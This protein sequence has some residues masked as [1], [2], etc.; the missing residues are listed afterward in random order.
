MSVPA[1]GKMALYRNPLPEV[2]R[3]F[4]TRHPRR[5]L[6]F[7]CCPEHPYAVERFSTAQFASLD[8]QARYA[9]LRSVTPRYAPLLRMAQRSSAS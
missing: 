5:Y 8:I 3:F 6:V 2:A 1:T 4:E 9:P 7:N